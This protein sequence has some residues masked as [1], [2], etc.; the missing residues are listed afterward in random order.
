MNSDFSLPARLA[1]YAA[2]AATFVLAYRSGS[3]R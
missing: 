1:L 2:A 3:T